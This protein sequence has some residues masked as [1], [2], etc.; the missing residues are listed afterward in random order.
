MNRFNVRKV[1][2]LGAGVMG[3]QIAAHLVNVK[4]PVVLFDLPAKEG[5]KNGIVAKAVEGLKKLKPAPL[6]VPEDAALIGQANYEEHLDQLKDCD[7]IIEAIAERMDWKL[8]L[9]KRIAPAIAPHA[10]VA[11]NTSGLSITKLSEA[12]PD[13]IKPRFC[14][15]HFFNPPRYMA[16]VELIATPTTN[17]EILDQLEAFVTS[18]L[19]KSVVRAKDTPNFIANRVGIAGML[20]T[21]KE[22]ENFGLSYDVVDDLT[23]KKMGR[24]SSGTF[25]TADVVGLDTMAHVIKTLQDN[26]GPDSANPD[27]FYADV[28]DAAGAREADRAGRARPEERRRLLQE[29]RQGHPAARPVKGGLRPRRR[30]GRRDRRAHPEEAAGR[31]PEAAA[32]VE[33]PAGPVHLGDPARQLPLCGGAPRRGRRERARHRLRDAL[34]LRRSARVRSSSGRP[35]AGA[36]SRSGSRRTSRPARRSAPRRCRRGCSR[37]R[38]PTTRACTARR[39]R[40]VRRTRAG[41]RAARCRSTSARPSPRTCSAPTRR[42]R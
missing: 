32:R 29:G 30:Q 17:P 9:Y 39:A 7:L 11:S 15:I 5:P 37:V 16:L 26:L 23:G 24:A 22:A 1:A 14:G 33:E 6:G 4:V 20:A 3:A 42:P 28:R 13:E 25:R 19:G 21:M 35:P 27:P 41:C 10:I 12:L 18:A 2:V 8:D 31:A 36:R 38:S 40:G 34:G